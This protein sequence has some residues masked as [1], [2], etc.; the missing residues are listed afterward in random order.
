[1]SVV[2]CDEQLD[3]VVKVLLDIGV[4]PNFTYKVNPLPTNDGVCRHGLP[5]AHKNLYGGF[6]TRRHTLVHGFCFFKL[7]LGI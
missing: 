7:F 6:N 1:M 5:L 3:A 4:S 2:S